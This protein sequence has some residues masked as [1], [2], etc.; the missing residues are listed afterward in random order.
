VPEGTLLPNTQA[1]GCHSSGLHSD[2]QSGTQIDN[3]EG[4]IKTINASGINQSTG[5]RR[6]IIRASQA[7]AP[8]ISSVPV[9]TSMAGRLEAA[10]IQA[11]SPLKPSHITI[12]VIHQQRPT[13][14]IRQNAQVPVKGLSLLFRRGKPF[15]QIP[16]GIGF[17]NQIIPQ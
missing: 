6:R 3:A 4:K 2:F 17:L 5:S 1:P 14:V 7:A 11:T 15:D 12:K 13:N 16:G 10:L 8:K 9:T